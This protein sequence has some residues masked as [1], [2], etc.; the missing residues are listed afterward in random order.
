MRIKV[1]AMENLYSPMY[2]GGLG[3]LGQDD[4]TIT[5]PDPF[6]SGGALPP[7]FPEVPAVPIDNL[8]PL[9]TPPVLPGSD[10]LPGYT[11]GGAGYP[12]GTTRGRTATGTVNPR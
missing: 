11:G 5:L 7:S 8:T 10:I 12:T 6:S 2:G 3:R 4:T 1:P 9:P